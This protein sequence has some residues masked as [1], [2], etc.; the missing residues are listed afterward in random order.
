MPGPATLST[1]STS[2]ETPRMSES[3]INSW[4]LS[5]H[6]WPARVRKSMACD[7]SPCVRLRFLTI[8][9]KWRTTISMTSR[10]LALFA[11]AH[12]VDDVARQFRKDSPLLVRP[13][14]LPVM[15]VIRSCSR[16]PAAVIGVVEKR[17][18][19]IPLD[20]TRI[21]VSGLERRI[22]RLV[23]VGLR[24]PD[25]PQRGRRAIHCRKIEQCARSIMSRQA[26]AR[27]GRARPVL[28]RR[29]T[30]P[31]AAG[32]RCGSRRAEDR[33]SRQERDIACDGVTFPPLRGTIRRPRL[34]T[35]RRTAHRDRPDPQ[36]SGAAH[37]RARQCPAPRDSEMTGLA[38][39]AYSASTAC[40]IALIP[41]TSDR[42]GGRP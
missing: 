41:D 24:H 21:P 29:C 19:R 40:A 18:D 26:R 30:Q 6:I 37:V 22:G 39:L 23:E 7:H 5:E 9:C 8:A 16:R 28:R 33:R 38:S 36:Q 34:Q 27:R 32:S 15:T 17:P 42:P 4:R 14:S 2:I 3:R 25:L 12:A 1:A 31:H 10:S 20:W 11:S 35:E 13:R